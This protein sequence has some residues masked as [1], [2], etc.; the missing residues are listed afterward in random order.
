[1]DKQRKN[2]LMLITQMSMGGAEKVFFSH[3]IEFSK[4]YNVIPCVYTRKGFDP[5]YKSDHVWEE[6]DDKK[7]KGSLGR[8]L[9]RRKRLRELVKKHKID[10]CISHM[11]GPN[12]LSCISNLGNCKKIICIHGSIMGD[13]GKSASRKKLLNSY[14]LPSTYKYA[15]AAVTVSKAMGQELVS[16]GIKKEKVYSIP[17]FFD[18]DRIRELSTASIGPFDSIMSENRT[19]VHV[20]RLSLQKNQKVI[21]DV[22]ANLMRRGR[23]EKLFIL[24]DGER[25][26]ELVVHA[27]N[28]GLSVYVQNKTPLDSTFD[29]YFLGRQENPYRFISRSYL[30]ILSSFFEGFPLVLGESLACST[31][32]ISVDCQ[33]GPA[34]VLSCNS[35]NK[36]AVLQ[37]PL[38]VYCGTLMP[39]WYTQSLNDEQLDMWAHAVIDVLDVPKRYEVLKA[40]CTQKVKCYSTENIVSSWFKLIDSVNGK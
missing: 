35:D 5:V 22:M 33:T 24:G 37:G 4:K 16:I 21:L 40:H 31:P 32:V 11:E 27:R 9:Y 15:D 12:I 36:P 3:L 8:L 38:K 39:D 29:V 30:F 18:I 20:G 7:I 23:T 14:I 28:Q 1:M 6:L 34:E 10:V 17:N 25:L 26:E 2:I 19:I 13:S